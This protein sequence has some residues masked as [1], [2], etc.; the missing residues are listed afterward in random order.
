MIAATFRST[1]GACRLRIDEGDPLI[2]DED[3]GWIHPSCAD[4]SP[5]DVVP[6]CPRCQLIHPG[7]CL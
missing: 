6:A 4:P 3:Y 5:R 7:E 1:C 2:H